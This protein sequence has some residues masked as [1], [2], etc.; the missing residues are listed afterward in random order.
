MAVDHKAGLPP[1]VC[2]SG[3]PP[4]VT[5]VPVDTRTVST[6]RIQLWRMDLSSSRD[7][8]RGRKLVPTTAAPPL[9]MTDIA[10]RLGGILTESFTQS[11]PVYW[12]PQ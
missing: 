6:E 8:L 11:L 7:H 3:A 1:L 5:P 4:G 12:S 10:N 2:F 9:P